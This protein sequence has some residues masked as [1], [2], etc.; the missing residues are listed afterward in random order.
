MKEMCKAADR[1]SHAN[2]DAETQ[3]AMP[4]QF[5]RVLFF[6]A[7][8]KRSH[9]MDRTLK[10]LGVRMQKGHLMLPLSALWVL[11]IKISHWPWVRISHWMAYPVL[12][13]KSATKVEL[14][15]EMQILTFLPH[16]LLQPS[17]KEGE[18]MHLFNSEYGCE[19]Y[20][21]PVCVYLYDD[22]KVF[23]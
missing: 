15:L 20:N 1:S 18:N 14:N 11:R 22:F 3:C 6:T 17:L 2:Q 4:C 21:F 8:K 7:Q 19:F 23:H 16:S 13:R 12:H 5:L 9:S 10:E